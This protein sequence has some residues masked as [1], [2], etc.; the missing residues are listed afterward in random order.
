MLYKWHLIKWPKDS[1]ALSSLQ[2]LAQPGRYKN[3]RH[4]KKYISFL[5]PTWKQKASISLWALL[6]SQVP[7]KTLN[8]LFS[9]T[10][11]PNT[12]PCFKPGR[13]DN[14]R[15]QPQCEAKEKEYTVQ[16]QANTY[17]TI[18]ILSCL[19]VTI[20]KSTFGATQHFNSEVSYINISI[21]YSKLL[22]FLLFV[23]WERVWG[24]AFNF[25]FY[26]Q[27]FYILF[28]WYYIFYSYAFTFL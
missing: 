12:F 28:N 19:N 17:F 20:E 14:S 2:P 24:F 16:C 8:R 5:S 23:F 13:R 27:I 10:G 3:V 22:C 1:S 15:L 26:I 18:K 11:F 4:E 6:I 21:V 9:E 7:W 25:A